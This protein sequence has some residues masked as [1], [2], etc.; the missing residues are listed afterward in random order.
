VPE[1]QHFSIVSER[2]NL[3]LS[4]AIAF[5]DKLIDLLRDWGTGL[6]ASLYEEAM[7]HLLSEDDPV[8]NPVTVIGTR[9]KL[10]QQRMR[11]AAPD[12]SFKITALPKK[13]DD[14]RIHAKRLVDH[15]SLR[16]IHWANIRNGQV[17]F[18]TIQ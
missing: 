18:E 8:L 9:S 3:T 10:G 14:F 5:R 11:L 12:V 16:A 6:S 17:T 13:L 4:S 1:L 2:F 7:M 15:T